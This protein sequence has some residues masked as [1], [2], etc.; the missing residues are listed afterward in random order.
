MGVAGP[1]LR[2]DA[3]RRWM[4]SL[5]GIRKPD[6]LLA[7]GETINRGAYAF[8]VIPTPGHSDG[9]FCLYDRASG[10]LLASDHVPQRVSPHV[11]IHV[12]SSNDP[13]QDYLDVLR[14]VR[15]LPVSVVLPGHGAPFHDLAGRVDERVRHHDERFDDVIPLRG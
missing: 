14:L 12:R 8:E 13:V 10:V 4:L 11:G 6:V 1:E 5:V 9:L 7:G 2:A 3:R 15:G